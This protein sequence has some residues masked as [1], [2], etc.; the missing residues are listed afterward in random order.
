MRS[1]AYVIQPKMLSAVTRPRKINARLWEGDVTR[2]FQLFYRIQLQHLLAYVN[3]PKGL[4]P[5]TNTL[6]QVAR[7]RVLIIPRSLD[8]NYQKFGRTCCFKLHGV[9]SADMFTIHDIIT[10]KTIM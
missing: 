9:R 6:K 1:L 4:G 3:Q 2:C 8:G 10:Q 5:Y 7:N